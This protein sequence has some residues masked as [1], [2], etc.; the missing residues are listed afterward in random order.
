[1][2]KLGKILSKLTECMVYLL[3]YEILHLDRNP[4]QIVALAVLCH[5]IFLCKIEYIQLQ[6]PKLKMTWKITL[7]ATNGNCIDRPQ[8]FVQKHPIATYPWLKRMVKMQPV[9]RI[10]KRT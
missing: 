5:R 3:E 4:F 8:Y 7:I 6:P 10:D 2:K 1:M 9:C